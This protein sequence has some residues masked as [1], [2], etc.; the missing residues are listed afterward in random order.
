M[1]NG[2]NHST[3]ASGLI[4]PDTVRSI[5]LDAPAPR[6]IVD[7]A[8][9]PAPTPAPPPKP[10]QEPEPQPEPAPEPE[11]EPERTPDPAPAPAPTGQASGPELVVPPEPELTT[12]AI[13]TRAASAFAHLVW[14]AVAAGLFGQVVGWS[15]IFG[16]NAA[17]YLISA[18]LGA[19]FEFVMV[20]ASSRGLVDIGRNRPVW[21]PLVFL[22]I[23]TAC[24]AMAVWMILTH[25]TGPLP[26][27]NLSAHDARSIGYAAAAC[28]ALGYLAHIVVHLPD[29]LANRTAVQAWQEEAA[30]VRAEID[31][32]NRRRLAER[33]EFERQQMAARLNAIA[34]AATAE[35][36]E[37]APEPSTSA[38]PEPKARQADARAL[39]PA[40]PRVATE[41]RPVATKEV[42]VPLGLQHQVTKPRELGE[43]LEREGYALPASRASLSNWCKAIKAAES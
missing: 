32:R 29:E 23:G 26:Q 4:V 34:P 12:S 6:D 15:A 31:E 43:L 37:P 41:D 7:R 13:T 1:V 9:P 22:G 38:K 27:F 18:T 33:D 21:Q 5:R 10:V 2:F 42:A 36:G 17:S 24:A 3:T 35:P 20:A 14:L 30:R 11:P 8:T 28:A 39:E 16:H 40:Q 25:F 19:T